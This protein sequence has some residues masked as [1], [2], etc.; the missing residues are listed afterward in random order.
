MPA[1]SRACSRCRDH[2]V[3]RRRPARRSATSSWKSSIALQVPGVD[4][5]LLRRGLDLERP[6]AGGRADEERHEGDHADAAVAGQSGQHVVRHVARMITDRP[7]R[8][9][10]EDHRRG[11]GVQRV[12]H[13]GRRHVGQV[14][15][16]AEPVHLG[17]HLAAEVGQPAVHRFVG[18][19]VGPVGV[20]VVGQGE[21][22]DAR[23]GRA[24][25]STPRELLIECPPSAPSRLPIRPPSASARVQPVGVGDQNQVAPDTARPSSYT[26]SI[27]SSVA[28]TAASPTRLHGHVHR[29]ELGADLP[30]PQPGQVGVQLRLRRSRCRRR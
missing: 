1:T 25:R 30:A 22:A 3:Q 16:H 6:G 15:Q 24:M 20:L 26:A 8:G 5:G 14:D 29:P 10:A 9:V 19:R 21:V 7:G 4:P 11:G 18:G 12:V 27:C 2:V 23:A 28:V 13:R 17:D